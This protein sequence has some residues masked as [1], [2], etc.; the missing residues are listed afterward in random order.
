MNIFKKNKPSVI[1]ATVSLAFYGILFLLLIII[2]GSDSSSKLADEPKKQDVA[3]QFQLLEEIAAPTPAPEQSKQIDKSS[4]KTAKESSSKEIDNSTETKD[5][6][7]SED[8]TN[9]IENQDSVILAQLK[10]AMESFT[11][12]VPA[13]SLSK[14]PIQKKNIEKVNRTLTEKTHYTE[15]DW[16]FIRNNYRLIYSLKIVYPYANKTKEIVDKLNAQ[17]AQMTD[18]GEKHRLIKETEKEL[19]KEFERDVRSMSFSQGKLLLKLIARETN[20]SAYGLIKTYKGGLPA[21]FWYGVGLLFHED[22]KLKYD[23][24]GEDALLEK[25]VQKYKLGKL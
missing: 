11:E 13:D 9:V 14:S 15:E 2:P 17:L 20:Q 21:T 6:D 12:V 8:E 3:V 23:S 5:I 24:T 22:L 7:Q 18:N 4:D 16:Q 1:A 19:Y 25:I 10:K